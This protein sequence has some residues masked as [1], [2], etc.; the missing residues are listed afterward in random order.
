[1]GKQLLR[2]SVNKMIQPLH[3]FDALHVVCFSLLH[4]YWNRA[5]I[6]RVLRHMLIVGANTR[7]LAV[8][9]VVQNLR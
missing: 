9:A 6:V 2:N 3:S 5:S 8:K 1:M 4:D 7:G